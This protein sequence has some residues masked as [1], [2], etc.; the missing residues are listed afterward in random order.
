MYDSVNAA[1]SALLNY[2]DMNIEQVLFEQGVFGQRQ[3]CPTT[4]IFERIYN[5]RW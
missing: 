5:V 1:F 3:K 4:S 2:K